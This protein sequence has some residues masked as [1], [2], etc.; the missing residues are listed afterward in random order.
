MKKILILLTLIALIVPAHLTAQVKPAQTVKASDMNLPDSVNHLDANGLKTGFWIERQ[1]ELTSKGNYF[2]SRK[3]GNWVTYYSN[4]ALHKLEFFTDGVKDGISLQFDRKGKLTLQENY[5]KGLLHGQT[6]YYGQYT[7]TPMSETFFA[8]G[9]KNGQFRQ[10]YD[11]SKIQEDTYFKNDLKDGS[12]R[13]YSKNGRMI[14][15][16]NY[17]DGNFEGLQKTYYEND[18]LQTQSFY[19]GNLLS[20]DY[21]E[22]YRNGKVKVSGKYVAGL[23][24]GTW[25][26]YDELGKP[27]KVTKFKAGVAK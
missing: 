16:Y 14:A 21:K 25:T 22:C 4:S 2:S 7:E 19:T 24:E 13:W 1:G 15:E 12:S 11:N 23:K 17:K 9:K 8:N 10:Y 27:Q 18:T 5:S 3:S 26:E 20:G 6:I